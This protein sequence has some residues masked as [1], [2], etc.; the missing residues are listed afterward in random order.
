[1]VIFFASLEMAVCHDLIRKYVGSRYSRRVLRLD[2]AKFVQ[3]FGATSPQPLLFPT[4]FNREPVDQ[5]FVLSPT[6]VDV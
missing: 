1:M 2:R 4:P 6:R 3:K 5:K